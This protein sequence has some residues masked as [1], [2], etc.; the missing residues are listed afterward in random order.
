MS[1]PRIRK[2]VS[3]LQA[4][5]RDLAGQEVPGVVNRIDKLLRV[6]DTGVQAQG[7][8]SAGRRLSWSSLWSG[9]MRGGVGGPPPAE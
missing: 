2:A 1:D 9:I 3:Y 7:S 5:R 6:L 4:W 8:R